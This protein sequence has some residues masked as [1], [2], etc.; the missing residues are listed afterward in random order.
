MGEDKEK[1]FE[2][3]EELETEQV[4]DEAVDS[5]EKHK[6]KKKE[7]DISRITVA[8]ATIMIEPLDYGYLLKMADKKRAVPN[9][10]SLREY[11]TM[12]MLS[13]TENINYKSSDIQE[14]RIDMIVTTVL[15]KKKDDNSFTY[16][17]QEH[18]F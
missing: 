1:E 7:I 13:R 8:E 16:K 18:L 5:K 11:L 15:K 6:K 12:V 14:M 9:Y 10:E 17:K 4:L 3:T 2:A